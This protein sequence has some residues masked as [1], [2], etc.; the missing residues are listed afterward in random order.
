MRRP[1]KLKSGNKPSIAQLS[2]V[3][4]TKNRVT[5]DKTKLP[6][7][8]EHKDKDGN[9]TETHTYAEPKYYEG[10]KRIRPGGV[11]KTGTIT[12]VAQEK[13]AEMADDSAAS[14]K[15]MAEA[16][17]K[18]APTRKKGGKGGSIAG[19]IAGILAGKGKKKEGF[20]KTLKTITR[21]KKAPT[22]MKPEPTKSDI[23]NMSPKDQ[24]KYGR[25]IFRGPGT[26]EEKYDKLSKLGIELKGHEGAYSI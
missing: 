24:Q 18:E 26:T 14:E 5:S 4:P 3:S 8:H 2:G 12:P 21:M 13:S 19:G 1:F 6:V 15:Q 10:T 25:K 7:N 17:T 16:G 20:T 11:D 22:R 23:A 9:V